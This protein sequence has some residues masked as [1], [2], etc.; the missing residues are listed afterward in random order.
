MA[1]I[2][3][4]TQRTSAGRL[5]P[6]NWPRARRRW[7]S[8][9]TCAAPNAHGELRGAGFAIAPQQA[10][11]KLEAIVAGIPDAAPGRGEAARL[12]QYRQ[13]PDL[14]AERRRVHVTDRSQAWPIGYLD[15]AT[16]AGTSALIDP[17]GPGPGELP[18]A[19]ST[20][21]ARSATTDP[22]GVRRA[23]PHHRRHRRPAERPDRPRREAAG[24]AKVTYGTS[25]TLDARHRRAASC[26]AGLSTPPFVVSRGAARRGSAWRAWSISAGSALDWVRRTMRL[27]DHGRFEALAAS[28]HGRRRRLAF[29]PAL[30]GLGAPHGDPARRAALAGLSVGDRSGADRPRGPGGRRL[31]GARDVRSHH[32]RD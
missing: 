26:F 23:G 6:A 4:T 12:G 11:A 8:G 9:A 5:G 25:A 13:L 20:P 29:L 32:W 14:E 2:G 1:A 16:W 17:P 10:A 19:W 7:W 3:V 28:A 31:P 24:A 15:L 27:G 30:Q 21:G 18:A 22:G